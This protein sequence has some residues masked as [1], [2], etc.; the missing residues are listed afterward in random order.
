MTLVVYYEYVNGI[1]AETIVYDGCLPIDY[2]ISMLNNI[3]T[4]VS[5]RMF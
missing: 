1:S 3:S 4:A 5:W 2:V